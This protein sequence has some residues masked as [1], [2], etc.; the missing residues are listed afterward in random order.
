MNTGDS[1]RDRPSI[2]GDDDYEMS[3]L[4]TEGLGSNVLDIRE[5]SN[6]ADVRE[7]LSNYVESIRGETMVKEEFEA[8]YKYLGITESELE[9]RIRKKPYLK[10][11]ESFKDMKKQL[12]PIDKLR[13]VARVSKLIIES[14]NAFWLGISTI[15]KEKLQSKLSLD[16]DQLI[17]ICMYIALKA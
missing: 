11:I 10:V 12:T 14:I 17:M 13:A 16:A 8:A 1:N 2:I 9:T 15:P 6:A 3:E 7:S 4:I 5:G